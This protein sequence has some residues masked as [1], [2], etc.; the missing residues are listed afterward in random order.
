MY[1]QYATIPKQAKSPRNAPR[2]KAAF[3]RLHLKMVPRGHLGF[4]YL[5]YTYILRGVNKKREFPGA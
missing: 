2:R 3:L 1:P 4:V 5:D